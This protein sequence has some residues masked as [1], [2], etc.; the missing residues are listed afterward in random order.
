MNT[1][2]Q[3]SGAER[4]IIHVNGESLFASLE[5]KNHKKYRGV[6]LVVGSISGKLLSVSVEAKILGIT[7]SMSLK[8]LK[9]LFPGV[10][11][12][13][14]GKSLYKNDLKKLEGI[15]TRYTSDVE[16]C[17]N[18]SYFADITGLRT[19][20]TKTYKEIG[21]TIKQDFSNMFGFSVSVAL[22]SS[23]VLAQLGS[24]VGGITKLSVITETNSF[25]S[26]KNLFIEDIWNITPATIVYLNK[27][28]IYSV[29]DLMNLPEATVKKVFQTPIIELWKELKGMSVWHDNARIKSPV[30]LTKAFITTT[31]KASLYSK[32]ITQV[33][34]G[35]ARSL[36][37]HILRGSTALSSLQV[38]EGKFIRKLSVP[39][40][41][42]VS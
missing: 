29:Y 5:Q 34:M 32:N 8:E 11:L 3:I 16:G 17:G 1:Q 27:L 22:A 28:R 37:S 12:I 38:R 15:L 40:L 9:T 33:G 13:R 7:M 10:V 4:A 35:Y 41:G 21:E 30:T 18:G 14:G 23:K 42:K 2:F 26:F 39:F 25:T 36:P 24:L 31:Q 6:P 20:H 19:R